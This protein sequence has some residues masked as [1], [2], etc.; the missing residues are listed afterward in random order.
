MQEL[1]EILVA[2]KKYKATNSDEINLREGDV[3]ELV[4][5]NDPSAPASKY[6]NV[7]LIGSK[8]S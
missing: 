3:V 5:T 8:C 1:G 7:G 4:D 6:V 2:W